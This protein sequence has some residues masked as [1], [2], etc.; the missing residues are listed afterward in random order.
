MQGPARTVA[1]SLGVAAL[2]VIGVAVMLNI[3]VDSGE[4]GRTNP[5]RAAYFSPWLN[6]SKIYTYGSVLGVDVGSTKSM[7]IQTIQRSGFVVEPSSWGD[8]RAG[9]ADLYEPSELLAT[10]LRQKHLSFY[11]PEDLKSGIIL[12]FQGDRVASIEAYY[13]NLE[14]P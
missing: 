2:S 5:K 10:M 4:I 3:S 8:D 1:I 11:D 7:A 6:F 12:N 13:I 14:G 9:G